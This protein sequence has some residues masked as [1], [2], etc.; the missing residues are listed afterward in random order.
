MVRK[1]LE[2]LISSSGSFKF[3]FVPG[4]GVGHGYKIFLGPFGYLV[5]KGSV[6][7]GFWFFRLYMSSESSMRIL[8]KNI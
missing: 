8:K 4:G 3:F 2:L 1:E 6:W 7:F 5:L